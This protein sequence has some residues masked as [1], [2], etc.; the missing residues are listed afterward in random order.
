MPMGFEDI[1]KF[2]NLNDVQVNVF[3]YNSGPLF[4]LKILSYES[5]FVMDL[6]LLYNDDHD[7]YVLITH[8]VKVV[9]YV[10]RIDFR[11]C[12]RICR[13]C[14]LICRDGLESCNV[15]MNNCGNNAPAVIHKPSSDHNSYKVTI[16]SAT[17]SVPLVIYF[18]FESFLRPVSG[19][20][21]P[22]SRAFTQVKEVH[23]LCGLA[24]R[25]IDQHS[26][27]PSRQFWALYGFFR[28]IAAKSCK[29]YPQA[30]EKISNF[31][32]QQEKIGSISSYTMLDLW[33]TVFGSR[34]S[35]KL[36]WL[37]PLSLEWQVS[38]VG[39]RKVQPSKENINFIPVVGHNIEN[40]HLHHS[41]LALKNFESTT[42]ISV[43]PATDKKNTS[44]T[45]GVLIDTFVK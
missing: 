32:R 4:P 31:E 21:G 18:D 42:T 28:E 45:F 34:R 25:V 5:E 9:C 26:N 19:C 13:N 35:R 40:Y 33:A 38:R 6:L 12:Y 7:H 36:D 8:I 39:A 30:K 1:P 17:W 11:Y 37:R 23:E 44:M 15:H 27:K 2:E 24:L 3:G 41:V 22:S 16:L 10:R 43:I 20:R 14:F 29:G